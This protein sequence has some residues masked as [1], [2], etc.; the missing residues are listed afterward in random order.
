M[1]L[2]RRIELGNPKRII[3]LTRPQNPGM[4]HHFGVER[5]VHAGGVGVK[6]EIVLQP[7]IEIVLK[8]LEVGG[9][10]R[11]DQIDRNLLV[12]IHRLQRVG[13]IAGGHGR[14]I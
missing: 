6:S 4:R 2:K 7:G 10:H 13:E 9:G 14:Q 3:M 1:Q 12:A 8:P 5:L 11:G